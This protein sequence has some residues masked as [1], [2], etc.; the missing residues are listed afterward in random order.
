MR[1]YAQ[2]QLAT[3]MAEAMYDLQALLYGVA[4]HLA[5]QQR[6]PGYDYDRH[7]GG[8]L[9]LF[10]RGMQPDAAGQRHVCLAANTR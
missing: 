7:C 2:P 4:L 9:Y 8:A 5:L 3:A 10:L 6:L 1:D